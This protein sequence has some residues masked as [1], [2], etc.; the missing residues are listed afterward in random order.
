MELPNLHSLYV[1]RAA[2]DLGLIT[3]VLIFLLSVFE[4]TH[5][6]STAVSRDAINLWRS[7]A[8]GSLFLFVCLPVP[9]RPH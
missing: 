1:P 6:H 7:L 3:L 9:G 5:L 4:L 2:R 8:T